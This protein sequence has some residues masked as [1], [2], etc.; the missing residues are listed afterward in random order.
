MQYVLLYIYFKHGIYLQS[1]DSIMRLVYSLACSCLI[2]TLLAHTKTPTIL[3][4]LVV[5]CVITKS[6]PSTGG[7]LLMS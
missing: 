5:Y 4:L 6:P 3:F 7:L 2:D 1:S